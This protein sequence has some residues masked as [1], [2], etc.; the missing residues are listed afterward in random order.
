MRFSFFSAWLLGEECEEESSGSGDPA[1]GRLTPPA[2]GEWRVCEPLHHAMSAPIA[3]GGSLAGRGKGKEAESERTIATRFV[4]E[5]RPEVDEA[6]TRVDAEA[7][8]NDIHRLVR[9]TA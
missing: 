1:G 9:V 8:D 5:G 2:V 3:C 4:V 6:R 7:L